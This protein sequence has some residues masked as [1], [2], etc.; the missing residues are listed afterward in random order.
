MSAPSQAAI[1]QSVEK[2][3][4]NAP[5]FKQDFYNILWG[6][7]EKTADAQDRSILEINAFNKKLAETLIIFRKELAAESQRPDVIDRAHLHYVVNTPGPIPEFE[8][9]DPFDVFDAATRYASMISVGVSKAPDGTS[10]IEVDGKKIPCPEWGTLPGWSSAW[11]L[12]QVGPVVNK[13]RYGRE[14]LI[15]SS[16]FGFD[17]AAEGHTLENAM[18]MADFSHAAYFGPKFL[19]HLLTGWGYSDFKWIEDK[20]TD[21]QAFAC[22]K[23]DYLVLC[24][25]GTSS[26]KDAITDANFFKSDAF[27]G[28][29]RVH[30]GFKGALDSVW[31][32]VIAVMAELNLNKT[33]PIFVSGHSLGAALAQ[34]AAYR[35]ALSQYHVKGVYV[36]GSPRVGNTAFANAYNELIDEV[37]YL[38]INND[39]IVA[40]V[41]PP[42]LG[43]RHLGKGPRRFDRGHQITIDPKAKSLVAGPELDWDDLD[44][45][46]QEEIMAEMQK[47]QHSM[48]MNTAFLNTPPEKLVAGSYKGIFEIGAI[49]DH[50]MSEYLF[51]FGCAIVD[52]EWDRINEQEGLA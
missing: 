30:R 25:R 17:G 43:F 44:E 46:Q 9:E 23:D 50:S 15:L 19:Q 45:E 4:N 29:G 18:V 37:T 6:F 32:Q 5:L 21:T 11:S 1:Q 49:D 52:G 20:G 42:I 7:A 47:V 22:S 14:D 27:G 51:K 34:L 38:H 40:R 12:R 24:F 35:L 2:M 13:V 48:E 41:P 31:D 26:G 3:A 16:A 33:K 36:Y 28:E 10:L 8:D 39:D